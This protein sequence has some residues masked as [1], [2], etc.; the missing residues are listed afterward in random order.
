VAIPDRPTNLLQ[1]EAPYLDSRLLH[2][3]GRLSVVSAEFENT[4]HQVYWKYARLNVSSG[5]IITGDLS[6]NRLTE[7]II[8]HASLTERNERRIEDLKVIFRQYREVAKRRNQCVHWLWSIMV[9]DR[10]LVVRP[11]YKGQGESPSFSIEEINDLAGDMVWLQ[12]RLVMHLGSDSAIRRLRASQHA[13]WNPDFAFPAPWL[14]RRVRQDPK[15]S[16]RRATRK[17]R[18]RQRSPSPA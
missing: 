11:T 1:R 12:R 7:D 8:K 18:R 17:S 5:P 16:K 10:A 13:P 14:G 2:A 15:S 3:I 9:E 6:P 4:C